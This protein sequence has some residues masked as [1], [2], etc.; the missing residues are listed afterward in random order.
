M[1]EHNPLARRLIIALSLTSVAT[2]LSESTV[3]SDV[4]EHLVHIEHLEAAGTSSDGDV[5]WF[6][7]LGVPESGRIRQP[8]Q[9]NY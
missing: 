1:A 2:Q 9:V 4:P 8:S 6:C 5:D 3:A 7:F